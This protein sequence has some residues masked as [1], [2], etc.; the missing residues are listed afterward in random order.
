MSREHNL[1]AVEQ[2][3]LGEGREFEIDGRLIA[4]FRPRLE[5]ASEEGVATLYATQARCPH[6]E[7]PLV[8]GLLG[9]ATLICPFHSWKFDLG[10]GLPV[11]GDCGLV[12]YA[13]RETEGGEILVVV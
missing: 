2:I 4:V 1:G 8:D 10:T 3:P 9:G 11:L 6:K 5:V 12:T 7:G 13:V